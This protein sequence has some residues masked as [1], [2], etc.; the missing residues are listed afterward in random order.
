MGKAIPSKE[1]GANDDLN[2]DS[3]VI[4]SEKEN[5]IAVNPITKRNEITFLQENSRTMRNFGSEK[6]DCVTEC[7]RK[8]IHITRVG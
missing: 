6:E 2:V 7:R 3:Y 4:P 5:N 8:L 1:I